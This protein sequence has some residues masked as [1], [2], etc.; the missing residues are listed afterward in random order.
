MH[1]LQLRS[2][3]SP[4]LGEKESAFRAT[5]VSDN[6]HEKWRAAGQGSQEEDLQVVSRTVKKVGGLQINHYQL[7]QCDGFGQDGSLH[8]L[9]QNIIL[10]IIKVRPLHRVGYCS[11][12][13]VCLF[14]YLAMCM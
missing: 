7:L 1:Q 4:L 11:C 13:F 10:L 2:A 12:L 14:L 6:K 3:L 8:L 5:F 9:K